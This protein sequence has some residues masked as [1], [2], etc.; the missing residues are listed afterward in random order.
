MTREAPRTL[1]SL[2]PGYQQG[3]HPDDYEVIVVENGSSAP[4]GA[5][6]GEELRQELPLLHHAGRL[7]VAGARAQ[8][9]AGRTRAATSSAS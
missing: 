2:S 7:A 6:C 9:R 3:I 5:G 4:L 8:L 1:R